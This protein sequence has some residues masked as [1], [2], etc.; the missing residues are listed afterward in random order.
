M[1]VTTILVR[2]MVL[3]MM[4][5]KMIRADNLFRNVSVITGPPW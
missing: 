1:L 3:T 4:C 5:F 2:N